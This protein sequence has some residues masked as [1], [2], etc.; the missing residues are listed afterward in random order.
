MN[1]PKCNVC[2]GK[3]RIIIKKPDGSQS[4]LICTHCKPQWKIIRG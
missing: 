2:G 1:K 3:G 4:W